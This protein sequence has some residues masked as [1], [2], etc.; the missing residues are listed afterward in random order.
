[1]GCPLIVTKQAGDESQVYCKHTE[2]ICE[3][4]TE[5]SCP[6][7]DFAEAYHEQKIRE[8]WAFANQAGKE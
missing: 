4:V 6:L 3:L 5:P 8:H 7:L 2:R 1:M